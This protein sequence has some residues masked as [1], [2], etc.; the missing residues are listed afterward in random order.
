ML[1]ILIPTK[2]EAQ[3]IEKLFSKI[4]KIKRKIPSF[5]II[6]TDSNS[7][8]N[9]AGIAKYFGRKYK[10]RVRT[11]NTGNRDLSNAIVFVLTKVKGNFVCV[12]DADLQ[13][14]PEMISK[15]LKT[16]KKEKAD[17]IIASRFVKKAKVDFGLWRL[18]VSKVY[19]FLT[20]VFVPK[21]KNIKDPGT[22]FFIFRKK[23]L[24]KTKL[25]PLGFK[26]L[27]EILAK[28]NYD[29]VIEIPFSFKNRKKGKSKFNFKQT[30]IAFKHLLKLSKSQKEHKK[31]LKFCVVGL[32]GIII[33]EGLLWILTDF[34]GFFYLISS[35]IAIEA[36]ILS[37]FFL[38][39]IWTFKR[40]GK[41]R[42]LA[43][44]GK[45][46]LARI[47]ALGINL[48]ILGILTSLGLHYLISNLIGIAIAT[49]FTYL[50]SIWWVWK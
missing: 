31:F 13:H 28:A 4:S 7:K 15:M 40:Q 2:N 23:I 34:A 49:L 3:N 32:S 38:N 1:S 43:R 33:N 42:F 24:K 22:G 45:F 36:S 6:I 44:L 17:I 25:N 26:I 16:L 30:F 8:D 39:D 35:A 21:T 37:N 12:M 27:L 41:N 29:K 14:P 48:A 5:E 19:R 20:Y 47:V 50:S 11:F 18:F 10:L 46:N 9:T